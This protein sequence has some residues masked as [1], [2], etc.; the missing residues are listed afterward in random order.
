MVS[1][2]NEALDI[3]SSRSG[4]VVESGCALNK[5]TEFLDSR[6]VAY[7]IS[8]VNGEQNLTTTQSDFN[9]FKVMGSYAGFETECA[10]KI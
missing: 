2:G 7:S 9:K 3:E 10:N 8:Q 6:D 1:L 5:L 4:L